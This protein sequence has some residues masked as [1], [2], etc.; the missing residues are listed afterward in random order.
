LQVVASGSELLQPRTAAEAGELLADAARGGRRVALDRAGGD[1]I[2]STA[3][4]ARVI[5][6]EATDLTCIVEP[7]VRLSELDEVLAPHGQMLAL[8]PPGDPTVGECILDSLSGPRRHRYGAVR[9]LILGV[10]VAL[11]DGTVASSG[12]KVVKNVAGYDLAKLFCGSRGTL[13]LVVRAAL[14]LHPRPEREASAELP[15]ER[16]RDA[17]EAVRALQRS[18]LVPS[19][20]D[21]LWPERLLVMFEGSP[22]VVDAQLAAA[23]RLVGASEVAGDPWTAVRERQGRADGVLA[24]APGEL[25]E[26]L[27][28]ER[29]AL[30]RPALGVAY[31]ERPVKPEPQP[32]LEA[33]RA[34][35]RRAFDPE[36]ILVD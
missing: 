32:A 18:T 25:E 28:H 1:V 26:L 13:G 34:R 7:G 19:A 29:S 20:L 9:D 24:F 2:V 12:G 22:R 10:T 4:M 6:H 36:G 35:V 17:R 8:D 5:E 31:V 30:V 33:L 3:A 27:R 16:T 21:L 14:R 15:L 23:A 11:V